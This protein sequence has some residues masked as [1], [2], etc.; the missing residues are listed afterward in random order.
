M[1]LVA[2]PLMTPLVLRRHVWQQDELEFARRTCSGL[3]PVTLVDIGANMGLFSRQL[4]NARPEIDAVF[5]Y[6]PE[7]KNFACMVHNLAPFGDKIHA[8]KAALSISTGRKE[9]YLDPTN[10]G[11]F[12]LNRAA[13]PPAYWVTMIKTQDVASECKSWM[14]RNR[15]VFYKSD[16]EALDE[17]IAAAILPEFWSQVF[18][19]VMELWRINKPPFDK[20]RFAAMLDNFPNK[21]FLANS[22][23]NV[24]E[25]AVSTGD[26]LDYATGTDRLHRD[27]G[28]WR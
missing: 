16:T 10:A 17:I 5:A 11:N 19:G 22:D 14:A 6:E 8:T 21:I 1:R 18:A 4:L 9:F 2:D 26:V 20:A 24:S 27:L 13:M 28:F 25:V 15:R 3:E 23:L 12:S 7:S